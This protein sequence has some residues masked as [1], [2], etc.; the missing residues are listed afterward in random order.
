[1]TFPLEQ[2]LGFLGLGLATGVYGTLIGAGGGFVLMP[3]LLLLYPE[4]SPE[5]LT[6]ISLAVVFFN[7]LSGSEAYALM[8][9]V[10]YK[11]G[12][13]FSLATVPGAVVG[14]LSTSYVPRR[15]FDVIFGVLLAAGAVLLLARPR[16][17]PAGGI[18]PSGPSL[19][20]H[21][22]D[23][24]GQHFDYSFNPTTG[25]VLSLF[26]GYAS[27]FLGIGGGIIHVPAL[28]FLLDF[29]VHV[30]TATSHFILAIMAFT[31]TMVHVLTGTLNHGVHRT[32]Y[33]ALGALIGAQVGARL[34]NHVKDTWILR[35]LS[36]ALGLVGVRI[37]LA[38]LAGGR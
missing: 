38:G 24:E 25:M 15:T 33:L 10:D 19:T 6:S 7:A 32:M 34:S 22:V 5:L 14:A 27:S 36:L 11:S 29:P 2:S 21:L 26:V 35:S 28:V 1:M 8:R 12:L 20:R 16:S 9:R 13:L 23:R 37:I 31:G 17:R 3:L 30:A 18:P 4:E